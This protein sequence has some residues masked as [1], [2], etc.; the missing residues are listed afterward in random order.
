MR[1]YEK[2]DGGRMTSPTDK[3]PFIDS[4]NKYLLSASPIPDIILSRLF[5]T[6]KNKT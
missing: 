4:F 2:G 1:W 5:G 3:W 6:K